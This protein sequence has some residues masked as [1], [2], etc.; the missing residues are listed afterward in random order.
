MKIN[1]ISFLMAFASVLALASCADDEGNYDY[2][3]LGKLT[4]TTTDDSYTA[5]QFQNFKLSPTITGTKGF[6]ADDYTYLWYIATVNNDSAPDTL[7]TEMNLDAPINVTPGDYELTLVVTNK[8]TGIITTWQHDI[9]VVNSYSDGLAVLS[10]KDGEAD[11]TFINTLGAVTEDIYGAANNG[12]KLDGAPVGIFYLGSPETLRSIGISTTKGTVDVSYVDFSYY[13]DL[14][15]RCYFPSTPGILQGGAKAFIQEYIVVDGGLYS[16]YTIF[17]DSPNPKFGAKS[18]GHFDLAPFVFTNDYNQP[19]AF[20]KISRAFVYDYYGTLAPVISMEDNEYFDPANMKAD[21]IWGIGL[22]QGDDG[23]VRA[24][25]R[26]D[27]GN[28]FAIGGTKSTVYDENWNSFYYLL[29]TN[30]IALTDSRV[31]GAT[32][33]A[34]SQSEPNFLYCAKGSVITCISIASGNILSTIDLGESI[35]YM[36]FADSDNPDALYVATS[37]GSG[38]A[39]SGT[40]HVL[41]ADGSAQL[42]EQTAYKNI[43][44]K[45]VDFLYK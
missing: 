34:I 30:R 42:S 10:S 12:R 2:T 38:R 19:Y 28:E 18:G 20:D 16:R 27:D 22:P 3:D 35:D 45:V 44:G 41:Q 21:I 5:E 25:M 1:Y 6:N 23:V 24:V 8:E 4:I 33:Y 37:N 40:V 7:S 43:C 31:K 32:T 14:S 11:V 29:P 13:E 36:E 39:A 17:A 26:D 15:D 9:A